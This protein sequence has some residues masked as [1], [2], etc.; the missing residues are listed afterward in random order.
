MSENTATQRALE[1]LSTSAGPS[2]LDG[3]IRT[4]KPRTWW[5]LAA[6][7][8]AVVILLIWSIVATVPQQVSSTGVISAI[9]ATRTVPAPVE[10]SVEYSVEIGDEVSKGDLLATVAAFDGGDQ[11]LTSPIT[12]TVQ[13]RLVPSGAGVSPGDGIVRVLQP[14]SARSNTVA[15]TYLPAED[16]IRFD[17]EQSVQVFITDISSGRQSEVSGTVQ[18]VSV[19]P[20]SPDAMTVEVGSRD[21]ADQFTTEANGLPYRIA[22]EL[23]ESTPDQKN[24]EP[25]EVVRI[26]NTYADPH[27]IELIFGGG[28]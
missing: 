22:I 14:A 11:E 5:A 25:G 4:T 8:V 21:L 7:T 17:P 3:V 13:D 10:G 24:V 6:I 20:S 19:I 12:G 28:Q 15:L 23:P 26:V 18:S 16:A 27:P 1:A 2:D 9:D